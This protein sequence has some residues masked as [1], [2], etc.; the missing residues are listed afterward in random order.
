MARTQEQNERMSMITREKIMAAGL[1]LFSQKGFS[2]TSIK[3]IAQ[4]AGISTG[5]IYRHFAT[6]E[7]LFDKLLENAIEEL[8][9]TNHF[10]TTDESPA[11]TFAQFTAGLLKD[12]LSS[13]ELSDYFLL[14]TRCMLEGTTQPMMDEF[15]KADISL[16]ENA[17]KL[18]EKGQKLGEFKQ[19]DPLKLSLLYFSVIQGIAN[20]KLFM[21]DQYVA[22][23]VE[24]IMD[25]LLKTTN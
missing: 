24:D 13:E 9:K 11:Q 22:P 15:R 21:G 18:I 12:I 23:E 10:L 4:S 25:F 7:E 1:R 17:A 3:D 19:G 20:M 8:S 6:K 2:M 5:L 16:F 14:I